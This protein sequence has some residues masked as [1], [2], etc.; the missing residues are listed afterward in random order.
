MNNIFTDFGT[1]F[2]ENGY[3]ARKYQSTWSQSSWSSRL[4]KDLPE[5]SGCGRTLRHRMIRMYS[6]LLCAETIP[7][8]NQSRIIQ[9][10]QRSSGQSTDQPVPKMILY[11]KWERETRISCVKA[12]QYCPDGPSPKV[13][14][15]AQR[16]ER[17]GTRGYY[18]TKLRDMLLRKKKGYPEKTP[19]KNQKNI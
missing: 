7:A 17:S 16:S 8:G 12:I 4:L 5:H 15:Q 1:C 19:R 9:G 2:P 13:K 14:E 18:F 6:R 11:P 10:N 3:P